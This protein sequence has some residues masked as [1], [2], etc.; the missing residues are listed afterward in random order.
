MNN[1]VFL[2]G[3]FLPANKAMVSLFDRGF[4]Y[5]DGVFET[6]RSYNGKVFALDLHMERLT[7]SAGRLVIP[8]HPKR[9]YFKNSI[10]KLL[11]LNTLN[12]EGAYIRLTI[13][14]GVD[15]GRLIPSQALKS[16]IAIIAKPLDAKIQQ[17]QRNGMRAVYLSNKRSLP[18]IKSINLL[19]NV[20]GLIEAKK[21]KAQ[22]G[23]FTDGNK[24]LEGAI[25]NIFISDGK[26][27]KTPPIEDGILPGITRRLLIE[28]ARKEG[29]EVAEISL[30]KKDLKNC[31]EAFLT[32]SIMEIVPLL[33]IDDKLVGNGKIGLLTRRLQQSYKYMMLRQP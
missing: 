5:G 27:I 29:I 10:E 8:F 23:I 32:N 26:S 11:K 19:S 9:I 7:E 28:L 30:S 6:M 3:Q 13:T 18:H 15:Y 24:I 16:T 4:T 12:H 20:L 17:Y 31:K 2:N 21:R 1:I 22:E 14:R 33:K 25:T